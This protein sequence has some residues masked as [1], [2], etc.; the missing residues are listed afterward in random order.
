VTIDPSQEPGPAGPGGALLG[1][2]ALATGALGGL[3]VLTG[4]TDDSPPDVEPEP[5]PTSV[6]PGEDPDVR[7]V[8]AALEDERAVVALLAGARRRH[9]SVRRQLAPALR[10]HQAHVRLLTDATDLRPTEVPFPERVA[11]GALPRL[12]DRLVNAERSLVEQHTATAVAARSGTLARVLAGMAAA[13]AQQAVVVDAL[14]AS[15]GPRP[16]VDAP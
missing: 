12:L 13:A 14:R 10:V 2:R 15:G 11:P 8:A 9:P 3:L 7:L 1:R 6:P 4:C 16:S 5:S